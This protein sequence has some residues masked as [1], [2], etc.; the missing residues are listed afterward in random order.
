MRQKADRRD[1]GGRRGAIAWAIAVAAMFVVGGGSALFPTMRMQG[2]LIGVLLLA[3]ALWCSDA[4]H[5]T[6]RSTAPL[7]ML[8][9]LALLFVLHLVPLPPALWERLPGRSVVAQ[10]DRLLFGAAPWRALSIDP[11]ATVQSALMLV[12][13]IALFVAAWRG[14]ER[15]LR[16]IITGMLA[17]GG[18]SLLMALVQVALRGAAMTYIYPTLHV[19]LPT[20]IFA[21]RNHQGAMF[22]MASPFIAALACQHGRPGGRGLVP[23]AAGLTLC[24]VGTLITGSRTAAALLPIGLAGAILILMPPVPPRRLI[25]IGAA[26]VVLTLGAIML[27][28]V[29]GGDALGA[30]GSR[31]GPLDDT[32][33]RFWP[34][35][36]KA[37]VATLPVGTGIGTFRHAYD[38][39]E[40]A[41][42]IAPLYVAHAHNDYLEILL[43][44][45][46]PGLL[47]AAAFVVWA[48]R[49]GAS[50]WTLSVGGGLSNRATS[51]KMRP[52]ARAATIAIVVALLHS[53]A[54]YPLRTTT[55]SAMFAFACAM[56]ARGVTPSLSMTK[57]VNTG[58]GRPVLT[59]S[60][61]K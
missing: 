52:L 45:G 23:V 54:D 44:S 51:E 27:I 12:P 49:A 10:G 19:G 60:S 38:L 34:A 35:V 53:V 28:V 43:E 41:A 15:R 59:R 22:V 40:P 26:L 20:G 48:L 25:A 6:P 31:A 56:L 42:L 9:A 55:L 30:L 3:V 21:N 50:A 57:P 16:A 58:D 61:A 18:I 14:S 17:A 33:F 2:Q 5:D 46:V 13:A 24:V 47:L 32:R 36:M 11:D 7:W 37:G 8:G 4:G 1:A 39:Y 29:L